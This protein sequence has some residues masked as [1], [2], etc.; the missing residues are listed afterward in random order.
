MTQ[1]QFALLPLKSVAPSTTNPRQHF[2]DAKLVEL[3]L[4]IQANGVHQ[5]ILVRPLP[6]H[7]V[8]STDRCVT[9][10]I[11]AGERRWRASQLAKASTIPAMVRELTDAE[12]LEI[13]I[14]ENL[15]RADL[16]ELEE[17]EGY[18]RL[19]QASD[20]SADAVGTKIGKSRSYVYARLKLLDLCTEARKALREGQIDASRGVLI[21]RIPDGKLQLKALAEATRKNHLD[22]PISFRS[23]QTWLQT[24]VMLRLERAPFQ[25]T[26]AKLLPDAGSCKDCPKRTGANPDLFADVDGA[27][28]CTDPPCFDRKTRAHRDQLVAKAEAKGMQVIEGKE[29]K[30]ICQQ[31][32]NS[33]RG[34]SRLDAKRQDIDA[35]APTLRKLLGKD[36]PNP[37]LIEHP[38]TKE[39]IEA[40]PTEEAE[41]MLVV[42]G[43][44]QATGTK[45]AQSAEYEIARLKD[46]AQGQILSSTRK[47][48]WQATKAALFA[49]SEPG[50]LFSDEGFLRAWLKD[51]SDLMGDLDSMVDMFNTTTD[52]L[53]DD[54]AVLRRI[55]RAG[56]PDLQRAAAIYLLGEEK[57]ANDFLT[58]GRSA[59]KWPLMTAA[60]PVLNVDIQGIEKTTKA[61]VQAEVNA[62]VK[63]LKSALKPPTPIAPAAQAS[64][65]KKPEGKG[66]AKSRAPVAKASAEEVMQG[67]AVAMQGLES[68]A[69]GDGLA[70]GQQV[71]TGMA[72]KCRVRVND[73]VSQL[74]L[75]KWIGKEGMVTGRV[76]PEAWDVTFKGRNGG[77]ASFHHTELEVL[78]TGEQS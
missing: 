33:L 70:A 74:T 19:M 4:S 75:K 42:K 72:L 10:E 13:Q 7:R 6:G 54:E 47:A 78:A 28:I 60:S 11:V 8:H 68:Q 64:N 66:Q 69:A 18:E 51:A 50:A 73:T 1:E 58:S 39:L 36:A 37:V 65:A 56:L 24:N 12:A 44:M 32:D 61:A 17:A 22:E 30:E 59:G 41:A 14:I 35:S 43:A 77:L 46:Q 2:D 26:D 29:A 3:S 55:E 63:E 34:Y 23:F 48:L 15:Q 16:T 9:H 38:W 27:D 67:I 40:V 31:Y 49:T 25:I 20:I 71:S 53:P 62:K 76:G 45:A 5:P 21:A 57:V 52:E